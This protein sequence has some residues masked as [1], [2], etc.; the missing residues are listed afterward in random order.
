MKGPDDNK[1]NINLS[2]IKPLHFFKWIHP[3]NEEKLHY[4]LSILMWYDDLKWLSLKSMSSH[5][6]IIIV[7][8]CGEWLIRPQTTMSNIIDWA[9][10][11]NIRGDASGWA[12]WAFGHSVFQR[13]EAKIPQ[14]CKI[15]ATCMYLI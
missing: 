15:G 12:G 8:S 3:W 4:S 14:N 7:P 10:R 13:S 9:A 5:F 11:V 6:I 1:A 2:M